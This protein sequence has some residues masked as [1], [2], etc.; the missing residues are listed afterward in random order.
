MEVRNWH[1]LLTT[2]VLVAVL[3]LRAGPDRDG[4]AASLEQQR[5]PQS[6]THQGNDNPNQGGSRSQQP[7]AISRLLSLE[8]VVYDT[9]ETAEAQEAEDDD[10]HR[11]DDDNETK[12]ERHA[13]DS[14]SNDTAQQLLLGQQPVQDRTRT[15][16]RPAFDASNI[17]ANFSLR[18]FVLPKAQGDGL[19]AAAQFFVVSVAS[20]T[21]EAWVTQ[22]EDNHAAYARRHGYGH[23][24][25]V[26]GSPEQIRQKWNKMFALR[27]LF[28]RGASLL[29]FVDADVVFTNPTIDALDVW[30]RYTKD[31]TNLVIARDPAAFQKNRPSNRRWLMNTGVMLIKN[32]DWASELLE[33][34][35]S[36]AKRR[37]QSRSPIQDQ[38][39]FLEFMRRHEHVPVRPTQEEEWFRHVTFVSQ[40]VMNKFYRHPSVVMHPNKRNSYEDDPPSSIWHPG[41]WM[42]HV[43][44]LEDNHKAKELAKLIS[45]VATAYA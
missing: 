42:A 2:A 4:T 30:R 14:S 1:V 44:G 21:T 45:D 15:A 8:R 10:D 41:D 18:T 24:R 32:G 3:C 43:A 16:T 35:L 5:L 28:A 37:S 36:Q 6:P 26:A 27:E 17:G 13:N 38:F 29:L 7:P 19:G 31:D 9:T 23:A 12:Q 11:D 25:W 22:T 39:C 33:L 40:M 20:G 34:C